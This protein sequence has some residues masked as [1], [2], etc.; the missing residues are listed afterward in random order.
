VTGQR[1][2]WALEASDRVLFHICCHYSPCRSADSAW[3][4]SSSGRRS[5]S[6]F[7]DALYCCN[8]T[9]LLDVS[10]ELSSL[11]P[12]RGPGDAK[13]CWAASTQDA[14]TAMG[15]VLTLVRLRCAAASA[16]LRCLPAPGVEETF[17]GSI[18][19]GFMPICKLADEK[20]VL[21]H[22]IDPELITQPPKRSGC[23]VYRGGLA[24]LW[25]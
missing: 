9:S 14:L 10:G 6:E 8:V 13:H 19:Q 23:L 20:M 17:Q 4:Q 1:P 2:D 5:Y 15:R 25:L 24:G 11:L 18:W 22:L 7:S 12:G 16:V 3:N 21:S